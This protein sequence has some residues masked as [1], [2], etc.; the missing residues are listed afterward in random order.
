[1]YKKKIYDVNIAIDRLKNY[2]AIQDRCQWDVIKKMNDWQLTQ[3]TK[4]H[5]LE[6]LISNQY[7]NEEICNFIFMRKFRI[8]NGNEKR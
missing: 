6:L 5:I 7:I 2:C 3:N 1:M 8:K 4:N